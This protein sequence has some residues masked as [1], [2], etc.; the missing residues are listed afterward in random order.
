MHEQS[1]KNPA[2][3][4]MLVRVLELG[5]IEVLGSYGVLLSNGYT[6]PKRVMY[7]RGL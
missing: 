7:P 1:L 3:L 4:P 5:S 6:N 2:F